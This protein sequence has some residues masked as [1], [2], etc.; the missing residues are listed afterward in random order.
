MYRIEDLIQYPD[1]WMEK[2]QNEIYHLL[3]EYQRKHNL[4]QTQLAK[5]LGFSKGYISQILNGNFNHSVKKL[6]ELGLV[7]DKVLNIRF[8]DKEEYI[9]LYKKEDSRVIQLHSNTSA[10]FAIQETNVRKHA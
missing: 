5:K 3:K 9:Q 8:L 2:I 4:N 6:I 1:Y 10:F 7:L